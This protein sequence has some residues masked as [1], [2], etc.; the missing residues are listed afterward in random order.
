MEIPEY[1]WRMYNEHRMQQRHHETQRGAVTT[2]TLALAGAVVAFLSQTSA[3]LP[4]WPLAVFLIVLGVFGAAFSLKQAERSRL[5]A[6]IARAYRGQLEK[7]MATSNF[8]TEM[9]N[10]LDVNAREE[11][12][13]KW[14][15][16][17]GGIGG[18]GTERDPLF[19]LYWFFFVFNMLIAAAGAVI[20][21]LTL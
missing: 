1:L 12:R 9:L 10:S 20:L 2:V 15:W 19:R 11:H 3:R 18:K 21:V 8:T 7:E 16:R 4:A 5:H 6:F 14:N 13:Q 17:T